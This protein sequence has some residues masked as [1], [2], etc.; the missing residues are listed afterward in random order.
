VRAFRVHLVSTG[1]SWPALNQI[2]CAPRF[3][4]GVTLGQ[5]TFP[6]R[7]PYAREPRKSACALRTSTAPA[8]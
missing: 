6:E 2:V 1:I 3:F 5:S 7:I 8:A 4:Y